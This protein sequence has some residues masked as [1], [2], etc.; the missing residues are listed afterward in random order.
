MGVKHGTGK[1]RFRAPVPVASRVGGGGELELVSKPHV[2]LKW[3]LEEVLGQPLVKAEELEG[4]VQT[5]I[6]VTVE[7][8]GKA[9][10]ACIVDT[11]SRFFFSEFPCRNAGRDR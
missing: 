4:G 3:G 10:P 9:R 2:H 1:V 11:I 7:I 5:T 6:R 8:E